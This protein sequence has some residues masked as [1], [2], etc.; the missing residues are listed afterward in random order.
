[1]IDQVLANYF[2]FYAR[3]IIEIHKMDKT[4]MYCTLLKN[5]KIPMKISRIAQIVKTKVSHHV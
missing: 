4:T 1:L 2:K 3:L 5:L